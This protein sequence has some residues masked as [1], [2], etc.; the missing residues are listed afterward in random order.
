MLAYRDLTRLS[1]ILDGRG[2]A[3]SAIWQSGLAPS[4]QLDDV[5]RASL[6]RPPKDFR[7]YARAYIRHDAARA[8]D[9][10]NALPSIMT[11]TALLAVI[12]SNTMN[13]SSATWFGS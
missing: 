3:C 9:D 7:G 8:F 11:P 5:D 6:H 10:P 2:P 4:M 1:E 12:A 13:P